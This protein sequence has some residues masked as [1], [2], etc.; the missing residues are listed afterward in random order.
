MNSQISF[1]E[2]L[3]LAIRVRDELGARFDE[4]AEQLERSRTHEAATL[5]REVASRQRETSA[6]LRTAAHE[7]PASAG[8][9][10][11]FELPDYSAIRAHMTAHQAL[12]IAVESEQA[13]YDWFSS[14]MA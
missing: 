10:L 3:A 5:L 9:Q 1:D 6:S 7:L 13:V 2:A 4:L 14:L 11:A 8:G 12:H